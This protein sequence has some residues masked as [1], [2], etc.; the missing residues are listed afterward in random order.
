M[1]LGQIA[2]ADNTGLGIQSWEFARHMHPAKTLVVDLGHRNGKQLHPERFPGA[3]FI[4]GLPTAAHFEAFL[5]GLDVV[6]GCET[7]YGD[8]LYALAE[9]RGVKTVLQYNF[10][11]LDTQ[12]GV[13]K[14]TLFAAPST[15]RYNDV[16]YANKRLLPVPIA[17]DRFTSRAPTSPTA[18][19][20]LH[21][22]GKP[23]I[24][25]R[26]G[27]RDLLTALQYVQSEITVKITCQ[28]PNYVPGVLSGNWIPENVTLELSSGDV[29][30]Y[31]DLY[32][33]SDVLVLPRRFGGLCL[34]AQEALGA[35]MPVVMPAISPN[36]WL[37]AEWLVPA[38]KTGEFMAR[39]MI[40]LYTVD[41]LALA[42]KIDQ[43]ASDPDLYGKAVGVA[44]DLAESNSWQSLKPMYEKT[45]ADVRPTPGSETTQ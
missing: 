25:D 24:H 43:F 45:F 23:A 16:P 11:F 41:H 36:E 20:F 22:V 7:M 32:A 4:R 40:E 15:W 9:Q 10:E 34:P 19:R 14:P 26:N 18:R 38:N 28:D 6:F 5:D 13:P 29:G 35:G 44:R 12:S 3:T 2:R 39:S 21:I 37:P 17:T 8:Y 33:D 42:E 30:D 1:R 27:T 31:W